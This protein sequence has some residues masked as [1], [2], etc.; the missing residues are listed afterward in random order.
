MGKDGDET[1]LEAEKTNERVPK[2]R[3]SVEDTKEMDKGKIHPN[4]KVDMGSVD[5]LSFQG[6][7]GQ[8]QN[9]GQPSN[10]KEVKVGECVMLPASLSGSMGTQLAD[11]PE[12]LSVSGN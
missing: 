11:T 7:V 2:S 1:S 8:F 9:V 4:R 12:T 3:S 10:A 5:N 6:I